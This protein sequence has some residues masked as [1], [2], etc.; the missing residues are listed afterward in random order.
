MEITQCT[1]QHCTVEGRP[2]AESR[3][4]MIITKKLVLWKRNYSSLSFD[5]PPEVAAVTPDSLVGDVGALLEVT[6]PEL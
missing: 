4:E 2:N 5:W 1:F 6:E 3:Q